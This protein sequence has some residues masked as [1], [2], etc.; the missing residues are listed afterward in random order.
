MTETDNDLEYR[1]SAE[2]RELWQR[3]VP[4]QIKQIEVA[5]QLHSLCKGSEASW[6]N[7]VSG[8]LKGEEGHLRSVFTHPERAKLLADAIGIDVNDL[9]RRLRAA[10]EHGL[11]QPHA[12]RI[13]SFEDL[14]LF[15]ILDALYPGPA[16]GGSSHTNLRGVPQ[17]SLDALFELA[18][19]K[20]A[21]DG[22][23]VVLIDELALDDLACLRWLEAKLEQA[24][25][26]SSDWHDPDL[27]PRA[28]VIQANLDALS[29]GQRESL[30]ARVREAGA[31]LFVTTTI[32]DQG[33]DWPQDRIVYQF[34]R[35]SLYW[36]AG[37]LEHLQR[38]LSAYGFA[39]DFS[40]LQDWL[41][42][43]PR[44]GWAVERA[45][46]LGVVARHVFDGKP[47]PFTGTDLLTHSVERARVWLEGRGLRG[48]ASL[49]HACGRAALE[50]MAAAMCSRGT[51][52]L[53][54]ELVVRHFVDAAVGLAGP[55]AWR[56]VAAPGML[57]V[58]AELI[59]SGLLRK[60]SDVLSTA[61]HQLAVVALGHYIATH[62]D[63]DRLIERAATARAWH[64][65]F[66]AAAEALGDPSP[67][68]EL[69][70]QR[71]VGVRHVAMPALTMVLECEARPSNVEQ[72]ARAHL[73]AVS[74]WAS[75]PSPPR[76]QP[77]T[78]HYGR[79]RRRSALLTPTH[80]LSGR[81]ALVALGQTS[82]RHRDVLPSNWTPET[83]LERQ[84]DAARVTLGHTVLDEA[85]A[86]AALLIAAAFQV[87]DFHDPQPWRAQLRTYDSRDPSTLGL[88]DPD[89]ALWWRTVAVPRL[90][91]EPD[92]DARLI[93][94]QPGFTVG[95][96]MRQNRRGTK[97]WSE[98]LARELA[99]KRPG[100]REAFVNAVEQLVEFDGRLNLEAIQ[101][102][103]RG[104]DP[105]L[106]AQ[107]QPEL[108]A[109]LTQPRE[110]PWALHG[111]GA[112]WLMRE[113]YDRDMLRELW[114]VMCH[115]PHVD[116][117]A[118][119]SAGLPPSELLDWAPERQDNLFESPEPDEEQFFTALLAV[120][121]IEFL[122]ELELRAPFHQ[123]A[124]VHWRLRELDPQQVARARLLV[125]QRWPETT[126]QRSILARELD[127]R[128]G[129]ELTWARLAEQETEEFSRLTRLVQ[130]DLAS[131]RDN[132]WQRTPAVI[133]R[134][135]EMLESPIP[136]CD[137]SRLAI[138]DSPPEI[139]DDTARFLLN[140][141]VGEVLTVIGRGLLR[142]N[143]PP[144]RD[145]IIRRAFES[146]RVRACILGGVHYPWWAAASQTL[147]EV[148][149]LDTLR[150]GHGDHE[151]ATLSR[152]RSLH[153][154]R[155]ALL[156]LVTDAQLGLA[157]AT[158]LAERMQDGVLA[159]LCTDE[160]VALIAD[161][162]LDP[163]SEA[164]R[165]LVSSYL[166]TGP[167]PLAPLV[168]VVARRFEADT[169]AH[170]WKD[171]AHRIHDPRTLA[172][173]LDALLR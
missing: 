100:A 23:I 91:D 172:H 139:D 40:A 119:L 36:A 148:Y 26:P 75:R 157:A 92:S 52:D 72:F 82:R 54:H 163:E 53:E 109:R 79:V 101:A 144:F 83:L 90:R 59:E 105:A 156:T 67:I 57:G 7:V 136:H 142:D 117:R 71:S 125:L 39:V 153:L 51:L 58:V 28:T 102:I 145:T 73:L 143:P 103:W 87:V 134:L 41:E 46:S 132:P 17:W 33:Q 118:F 135:T 111:D 11:E 149:V 37:Y 44:S 122:A 4:L 47:L 93:G 116:W 42:D 56:Q 80:E 81:S 107:L 169:R 19:A 35:G 159:A 32:D 55:E 45:H 89:Y 61:Q 86:R 13:P 154:S 78:L 63:D 120:D 126:P 84:D 66:L 43:D 31:T 27:G 164:V 98:A 124:R 1:L 30:L 3:S 146:P 133:D 69:L 9:R 171:I 10:R 49:L 77:R 114:R 20:P 25:R 147:G 137:P 167:S 15:P 166:E 115:D 173:L 21:K 131:E 50:R 74:W 141:P 165:T 99:A 2:Q 128:A 8:F 152:I 68:I 96:A 129:D 106:R 16:G 130:A 29:D 62:Q 5:K 155:S 110:Y 76:E 121:D 151:Q 95:V 170:W 168:D 12:W 38:V 140:D 22:R 127:P 34:G 88:A 60:H 24:G 108:R 97:I 94:S 150:A 160:I 112:A 85:R 123:W 6:K 113:F 138:T 65:A 104:L 18:C 14:G 158:N 48:E 162:G 161:S 70:L 64:G